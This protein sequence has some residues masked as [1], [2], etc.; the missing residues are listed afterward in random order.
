VLAIDGSR[1]EGGGQILRS[2]L[3]LS[4]L[5]AT[6]F[7]I[8]HIRAR[9]RR[10]GLLRQHLAAV[11]AAQAISGAEVRGDALGS[12]ELTFSPGEVRG[13]EYRFSV[14][15]AGSAT[16]VLQ[17]VLLPLA[18]ADEPA[19]VVIEGGTHNPLAPPFDFL[20]RS[21]LPLLERMGVRASVTLERAGFAPVGGGRIRARIEPGILGRLELDEPGR[22]LR[23]RAVSTLAAL[24]GHIAE[25][26]LEVLRERLGL[27]AAEERIRA[28][29]ADEGPGNLVHVELDYEH[30]TLVLTSF[31]EKGLLAEKVS[32]RLADE[33]RRVTRAQVAVDPHLADQLLLPMA[34]GDGGSFTT[35]EPTSHSRT[36]AE[37]IR[38]FLGQETTFERIGRDRFRVLL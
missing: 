24:P 15:S 16:L 11:R 21:Y 22:L 29:P 33:V 12:T 5:S 18:L 32:L 30:V 28:L 38:L 20:E 9:R 19:E 14:G 26:E 17:T 10:P 25:R 13:G 36:H 1:G 27:H 31:G 4:V 34:L 3:A 7:T 8:D 35:L 37:V 6:P 23:R 2:S